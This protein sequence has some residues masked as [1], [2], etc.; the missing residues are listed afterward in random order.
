VLHAVLLLQLLATP[1]QTHD[2][3][4]LVRASIRDY[5]LGHFDEALKEAE[6]A[7]R[8][9]SL[10]QILFNIGQCEKALKHWEKAAFFYERY[11][12]KLPQ[13]PNRKR[14]EELLAEAQIR[15]KEAQQAAAPDSSVVAVS[16]LPP[17]ALVEPALP[18]A[19]ALP[20]SVPPAAVE[21]FAEKAVEAPHSHTAAYVLGSVAV[22]SLVF[23]VVGIVQVENFESVVGR[24]NNPVSYTAW[25]ADEAT[26][27]SQLSGAQAWEAV[28]FAAGAI[29]FGT[30]TAAALTW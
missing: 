18:P 4:E 30:G 6:A 26:A 25:K 20:E 16:P 9:D 13:A 19:A 22:V 21:P 28:A 8:L 11:L 14:V 3:Q 2:A 24:V 12:S 1:S 10:P 17:P 5:D 29:A 23:M 27:A 7:Y 15:L